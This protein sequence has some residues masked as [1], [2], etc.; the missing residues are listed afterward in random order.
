MKTLKELEA[1]AKSTIA[2]IGDK[3]CINRV[4]DYAW[5]QIKSL[6]RLE[7]NIVKGR[8]CV[9]DVVSFNGRRG[10]VVVGLV[11]KMNPTKAVVVPD[12][13]GRSWVVPYHMLTNQRSLT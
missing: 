12:D 2:L 10:K 9:G 7:G 13:G 6:R 8:L 1:E 3:D 4:V 5:D 11:E